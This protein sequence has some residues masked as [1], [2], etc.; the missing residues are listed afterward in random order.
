MD[1]IAHLLEDSI[2]LREE[3]FHDM[4]EIKSCIEKGEAIE[5]RVILYLMS[6]RKMHDVFMRR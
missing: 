4:D 2:K 1:C 3:D 6:N 5:S